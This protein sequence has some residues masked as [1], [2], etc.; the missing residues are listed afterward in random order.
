MI[1]CLR[2]P[3]GVSNVPN[4][5]EPTACQTAG[6]QIGHRPTPEQLTLAGTADGPGLLVMSGLG[7]R[8]RLCAQGDG[9]PD[10][11]HSIIVDGE[12][13]LVC[14]GHSLPKGVLKVSDPW[15]GFNESS[16]D[17]S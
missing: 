6:S 7:R 10:I 3:F 16:V 9:P 2:D 8:L 4:E 1:L 17:A 15:I 11:K 13:G 12:P 5:E 14:Q